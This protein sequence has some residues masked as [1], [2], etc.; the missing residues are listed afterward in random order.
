MQA[1]ILDCVAHHPLLKNKD[2]ITA[3]DI[4][5]A[6]GLSAEEAQLL[7]VDMTTAGAL[8]WP[9]RSV[10]TQPSLLRIWCLTI[11]CY[12]PPCVSLLQAASSLAS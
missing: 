11:A 3:E 4:S 5:H 1:E 7:V 12:L 9:H 6:I 8:T 10:G 2:E